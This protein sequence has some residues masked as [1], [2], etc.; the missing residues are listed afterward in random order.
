MRH[1]N[2]TRWMRWLAAM[3]AL[4]LLAAACSGD[5]DDGGGDAFGLGGDEA[6]SGGDDGDAD[7]SGSGSDD[8]DSGGSGNGDSGGSGDALAAGETAGGIP[9]PAGGRDL[10][11]EAGIEIPSQR[12]LAYPQD[13]YD[14]VVAFY[15]DWVASWPGQVVSSEIDDQRLWQLLPE[16]GAASLSAITIV[17]DSEE[18]VG[19]DLVTFVLLVDGAAG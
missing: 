7:D 5:D 3:A 16:D 4:V 15:E 10:L 19:G 6:D 11:A 12:Q 8:S 9:F 2:T 1:D 14:E 13:A 17:K 18:S